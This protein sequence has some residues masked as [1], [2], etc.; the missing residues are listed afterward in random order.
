MG[1]VV[2]TKTHLYVDER[3]Q[4]RVVVEHIDGAIRTLKTDSG[5]PCEPTT[6]GQL[7]QIKT[8]ESGALLRHIADTAFVAG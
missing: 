5:E 1:H 8:T 4:V 6:D 7:G 2:K 3:D